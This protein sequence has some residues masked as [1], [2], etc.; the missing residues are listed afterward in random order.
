MRVEDISAA[1]AEAKRLLLRPTADAA[2]ESVTLLTDAANAGGGE[3]SEMLAILAAAGLGRE[4]DWEEALNLLAISAE[5]GWGAAQAQL[6]VMAGKPPGSEPWR[7]M[8]SGID[9]DSWLKPQTKIIMADSP[10]IRAIENFAAKGMCSWIVRRSQGRTR[11]AEIFD[12]ATGKRQ[13]SV[14][15]TYS[16]VSYPLL[17]ADIILLSLRA[18]IAAAVEM[19]LAPFETPKVLHY[20]TGQSY[21]H[22]FDYLDPADPQMAQIISVEGQ[23]AVSFYVYLNED[24]EGGETEFPELGLRFR[25]KKGDALYFANVDE[26]GAPDPRTL[27]AGLA[28]TQGEKWVFTQFIRDRVPGVQG[29]A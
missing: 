4:P 15:R 19:P 25:G 28:P 12:Y 26:S 27:H 13:H 16:D 10:R 29:H 21:E 14:H 23:R 7:K 6:C 20:E 18:K 3:A 22:H 24:Y 8:R 5:R 11:R 2:F 9:I 1:T 17:D